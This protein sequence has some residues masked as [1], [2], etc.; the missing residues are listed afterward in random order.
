MKEEIEKLLK[1]CVIEKGRKYNVIPM[2][3]VVE[4]EKNIFLDLSS[5]HSTQ[6]K[7]II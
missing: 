4:M 3:G 1:K 6:T 2:K 5:L 7:K